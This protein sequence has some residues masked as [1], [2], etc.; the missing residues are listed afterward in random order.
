VTPSVQELA[1]PEVEN[2]DGGEQSGVMILHSVVG[3]D[4]RAS[5]RDR[6]D[7]LAIGRDVKVG[8]AEER[9]VARAIRAPPYLV[10]A[11]NTTVTL[12]DARN[13]ILDDGLSPL[14]AQRRCA[15]SLLLT[16]AD[17][18]TAASTA[19]AVSLLNP[20]HSLTLAANECC[21]LFGAGFGGRRLREAS[22]PD[23]SSNG[24]GSSKTL[25][26]AQGDS[27]SHGGNPPQG[28]Q[29]C[30]R[31]VRGVRGSADCPVGRDF[32]DSLMESRER[33]RPAGALLVRRARESGEIHSERLG[34]TQVH[35]IVAWF[36]GVGAQAGCAVDDEP[37]GKRRL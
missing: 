23:T 37:I 20:T 11:I 14:G 13:A 28:P 2:R 22:N 30:W 31:G 29:P 3:R 10:S 6:F 19:T 1:R 8:V 32:L 26:C 35:P 27:N 16:E 18:T 12:V 7:V 25:E 24:R 15:P 5:Q 4:V 34:A 33:S 9:V 21:W 17:A 36:D